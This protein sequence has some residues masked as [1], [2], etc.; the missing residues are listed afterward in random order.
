M[1]SAVSALVTQYCYRRVWYLFA[2]CETRAL[3]L[4]WSSHRPKWCKSYIASQQCTYMLSLS[5]VYYM[6]CMKLRNKV[7]DKNCWTDHLE[8]TIKK[9]QPLS[10]W[11]TLFPVA[12][13]QFGYF[14]FRLP[15]KIVTVKLVII[16]DDDQWPLMHNG[17]LR[18]R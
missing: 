18:E 13:C 16:F 2:P 11:T 8:V 15:R 17:W 4:T 1:L 9:W 14:C 3:S 7:F 12:F 5:A 6:S 10:I